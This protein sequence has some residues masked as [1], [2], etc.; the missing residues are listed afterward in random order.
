MGLNLEL[1]TGITNIDISDM[2]S[3]N[4]AKMRERNLKSG[5]NHFSDNIS[6]AIFTNNSAAQQK[7]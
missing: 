4:W 6:K 1:I 7:V 2:S 3:V 5:H